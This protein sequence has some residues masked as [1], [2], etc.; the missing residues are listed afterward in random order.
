MMGKKTSATKKAQEAA[1][2]AQKRAAVSKAKLEAIE[3]LID[4]GWKPS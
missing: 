3:K 1:R 4:K 2:R